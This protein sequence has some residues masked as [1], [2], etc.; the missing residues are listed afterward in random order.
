LSQTANGTTRQY[1]ASGVLERFKR[2]KEF[3]VEVMAELKKTSWPS[4][5]EVYGTT[6]VVIIAVMICA[7]YLW[8]VDQLLS[9]GMERIFKAFGQ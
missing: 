4:R 8:I 3:L 1:G 7:S 2:L 6:L 5:Q 9:N